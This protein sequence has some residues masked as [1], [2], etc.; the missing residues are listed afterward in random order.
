M[1]GLIKSD[2]IILEHITQWLYTNKRKTLDKV[3][4][5]GEQKQ[6]LANL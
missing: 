2:V 1:K 5:V 4:T 6:L 3:M